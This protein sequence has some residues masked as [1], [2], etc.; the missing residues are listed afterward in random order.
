MAFSEF[1]SP[2]RGSYTPCR[3]APGQELPASPAVA[4]LASKSLATEGRVGVFFIPCNLEVRGL[5][6]ASSPRLGWL[7]STP[8]PEAVCLCFLLELSVCCHFRL[9]EVLLK[10]HG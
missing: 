5:T 2:P 7:D 4:D 8:A 3:D 9:L 1:L 6:S 10:E